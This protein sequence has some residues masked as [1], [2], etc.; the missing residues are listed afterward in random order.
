MIITL[1]FFFL[2][3]LLYKEKS[4][5]ELKGLSL[6]LSLRLVCKTNYPAKKT[7]FVRLNKI[8][9]LP[10]LVQDFLFYFYFLQ[11]KE[12]TLADLYT[13]LKHS[14]CNLIASADEQTLQQPMPFNSISGRVVVTVAP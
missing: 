2:F 12:K 5:R 14:M 3:F 8:F 1:T 10:A 13:M 11:W 7:E 4:L 6:S 9:K